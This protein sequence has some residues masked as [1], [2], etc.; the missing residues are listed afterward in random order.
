MSIV[1]LPGDGE[2]VIQFH[3]LTRLTAACC[4]A[5]FSTF[6]P[7]RIGILMLINEKPGFVSSL[8]GGLSALATG[9]IEYL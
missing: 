6:K 7:T 8:A 2:L 4:L 9:H 3:D 5:R 1:F